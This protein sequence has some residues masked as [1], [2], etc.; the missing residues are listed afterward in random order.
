MNICQCEIVGNGVAAKLQPQT[1]AD[2]RMRSVATNQPIGSKF[3][4]G[5][6]WM[7]KDAGQRVVGF[8]KTCQLQLAFHLD[9]EC[10]KPLFQD[11]FRLGL[12]NRKREGIG[13]VNAVEIDPG[14]VSPVR[15]EIG[16]VKLEADRN[17]IIGASGSFEK[18]QRPAPQRDRFGF[19]GACR[20]LVDDAERNLITVSSAAIVRPTGP[21]PTSSTGALDFAFIRIWSVSFFL[22]V[23]SFFGK[24]SGGESRRFRTRPRPVL[25]RPAWPPL[26]PPR[27]DPR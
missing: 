6:V 3:L 25:L 8:G 23:N 4:L 11:A 9:A 1:F 21:A 13:R 7:P 24:R 2:G 20:R 19:V 16:G 18:F 22:R 5:A 27:P 14:Q 26:D 15:N 12:R 17:K 10:Q